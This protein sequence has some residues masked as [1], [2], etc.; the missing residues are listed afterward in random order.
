MEL[1]RN[2][3]QSNGSHGTEYQSGANSHQ[4][5]GEAKSQNQPQDQGD[6]YTNGHGNHQ[7]F[8]SCGRRLLMQGTGFWI[9]LVRVNH[10]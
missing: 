3:K 10:P 5:S 2:P 7:R 4:R 1:S 6:S 8:K 9:D